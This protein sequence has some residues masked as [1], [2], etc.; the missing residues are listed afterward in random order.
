MSD[1]ELL[2]KAYAEQL[3]LL[4]KI[5]N[6]CVTATTIKEFD[7]IKQEINEHLSRSK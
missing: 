6:K 3:E 1:L 4:L 2:T 7:F 5:R